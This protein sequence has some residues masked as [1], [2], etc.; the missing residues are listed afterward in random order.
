MTNWAPDYTPR[1]IIHY[2]TAGISHTFTGRVARG[3]ADGAAVAAV[4]SAFGGLCGALIPVLPDDFTITQVFLIHQDSNITIPVTPAPAIA[5]GA[6]PANGF[7]TQDKATQLTFPG[8]SNAGLKHHVSIIGLQFNPDTTT[9]SGQTY[10]RITSAESTP[11]NNAVTALNASALVAND[12]Q[13]VAWYA[14][15]TNKVNDYW[16]RQARKTGGL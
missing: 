13:E 11:V 7:S 3:T 16:W 12:G 14:Y 8:K 1:V 9:V 15:A 4:V 6:S 5:T 2:T 10:G